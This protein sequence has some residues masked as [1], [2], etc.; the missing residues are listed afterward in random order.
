MKLNEIPTKDKMIS[1]IAALDSLVILGVIPG[2]IA[3]ATV[4]GYMKAHK[5]TQDELR[6]AVDEFATAVGKPPT[7]KVL[8]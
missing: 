5:I 1:L 4:K 3:L 8:H 2:S 7:S 6:E